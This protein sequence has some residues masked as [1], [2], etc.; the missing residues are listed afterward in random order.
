LHTNDAPEANSTLANMNVPT[1]LL[2][3][4]ISTIIAQRLVRKICDNCKQSF[5]PTKTLLKSVGLPQTTKKLWRGKGCDQCYHTGNHGRTGIFEIVNV[6][7]Q[8]RQMIADEESTAEIAKVAKLKTM[9]DRCRQ[10]VK[11]GIVNPEEFLRVIRT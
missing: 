2:S 3:N 6:T 5:T 10:K 1:F 4:A 7:P 11:S 9:A 8:I